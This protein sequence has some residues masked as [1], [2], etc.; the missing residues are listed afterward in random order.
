MTTPSALL[1][2]MMAAA[3]KAGRRLARDFGEVAELQ[4]SKKGPGDFVSQA[5]LKA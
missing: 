2:V 3:R 1:Q 5:D 4:V